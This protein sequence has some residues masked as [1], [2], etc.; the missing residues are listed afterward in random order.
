[1][2]GQWQRHGDD[3]Y[4]VMHLLAS[5]L[6]DHSALLGGLVSKSRNFR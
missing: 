2:Y 3:K 4:A 6:I 5:K 1:V